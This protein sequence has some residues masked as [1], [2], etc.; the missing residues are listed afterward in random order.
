MPSLPPASLRAAASI[1]LVLA[2]G[3]RSGPVFPDRASPGA[4]GALA[5][6]FMRIPAVSNVVLSPDGRRV[7]G[8]SS[9]QGVQVVFEVG[10]TAGKV[11]LLTR[12]TPGTEV[13]AIGW[14]G[15]DMLLV[16]FEQPSARDAREIESRRS[17]DG[18]VVNESAPRSIREREREFRMIALRVAQWRQRAL[19]SSWPLRVHPSLPGA[20]I[21]W[22]PDDRDHVLINWWPSSEVGASAVLARAKDGLPNEVVPPTPGV[23][24][25]YADHEGRVRAGAG[26]SEDGINHIVVARVSD[27]EAFREV[28]GSGS[29]QQADLEFA[30]F[31]A[32][33]KLVYLSAPGAT[34][35]KELVT[36]DLA[37]QRRVATLYANPEYDVGAIVSAP[38][39][40]SLA[41]VEVDAEKP[42]LHFFDPAAE[43]E[44]ASIDAALPGTTNRIVSTSR[45]ASMAIVLARADVDPPDY[46]RYDRD[47]KRMDFLFTSNP[48]LDRAQLASMKPVRY[49][50]RDGLSIAAYLTVPHG[51]PAKNL[52]VI[53]LVHDGPSGRVSWGWDPVVQF[54]ASRGFAVFQPN[55]RG[56]TGYGREHERLGYRQ[57]GLAMQ[58][59]LVDGVR[60]LVSQ[61]IANPTRVGIYGIGYGGYAALLA[62]AKTPEL[63]HAAASYGAVTDLVDLLENPA[64]YHSTDLNQPVEG[65]LAGDREALAALSPARLG[66]Q[67]RI[68]VLVAHG[69]ADGVV[70]SDQ[71]RE[72]VAAV[73][74]A[75]G[76]VESYFYRRELHELLDEQNRI[77]FHEKLAAFFAR[78]L[79]AIESL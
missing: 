13:H 74:D 44:Q 3:C 64:H 19:D 70:D 26:R 25:W 65:R 10:R 22:L 58:D 72:M 23:N 60:W 34:G 4:K 6:P 78:H 41:A 73:E 55:Y 45:D 36:Y 24:V 27:R 57:W 1:A 79:S 63:F 16:A 77:D 7:A 67:V 28:T 42:E 75:G 62:A 59:D 35:R 30:G 69:L 50:A 32:D 8:L 5:E 61:G 12:V 46:C 71:S 53:V 47:H 66:A 31:G 38:L 21:H 9:N 39:D 14:S 15:D 11:D 33:P 76:S 20:V 37:K 51:A 43:R 18:V 52:P 29:T 48:N 49:A 68:P 54:L 17:P 2:L 56:S 40:G